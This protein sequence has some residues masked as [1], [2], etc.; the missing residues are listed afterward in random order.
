MTVRETPGP[1]ATV[2]GGALTVSHAESDVTESICSR[3]PP[4]LATGSDAV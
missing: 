1:G 2:V 3:P 4:A